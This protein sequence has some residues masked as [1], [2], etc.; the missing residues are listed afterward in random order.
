MVMAVS[1]SASS[2]S[3]TALQGR[4]AERLSGTP[5]GAAKR[6]AGEPI[7]E[8][9]WGDRASLRAASPSATL[10]LTRQEPTPPAPH[11][12][13]KNSPGDRAAGAEQAHQ[14][15]RSPSLP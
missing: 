9:N 3:R 12:S 14:S 8:A 1:F 10:G 6:G 11:S 13:I 15:G 5:Q 2:G 7:C 4:A